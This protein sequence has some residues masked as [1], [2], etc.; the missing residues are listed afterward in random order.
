VSGGRAAIAP[1]RERGQPEAGERDQRAHP[2]D[3]PQPRAS[4]STTS[5]FLAV[6][7]RAGLVTSRRI[8]HW[9]YYKR[10]DER[11]A[12]FARRLGAEL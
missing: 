5:Q 1:A 4:Q 11:I 9:T 8:G 7:Q 2:A 12:E 10:D 6:L 3:R